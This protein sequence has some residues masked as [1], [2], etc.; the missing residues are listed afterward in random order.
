MKWSSGKGRGDHNTFTFNDLA[1]YGNDKFYFC[2]Y[3]CVAEAAASVED[4]FLIII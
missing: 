2:G 4:R 3:S 1:K